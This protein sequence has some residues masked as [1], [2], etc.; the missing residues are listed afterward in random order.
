MGWALAHKS[1]VMTALSAGDARL[2]REQLELYL[3]L[4]ANRDTAALQ[5]DVK[6]AIDVLLDRGAAPPFAVG[7]CAT[8]SGPGNCSFLCSGALIAP[9]LV[10]TARHCVSQTP[11]TID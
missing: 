1:E 4:Y 2:D 11:Q 8:N 3:D 7:V 9:N 6:R 5:P 10:L